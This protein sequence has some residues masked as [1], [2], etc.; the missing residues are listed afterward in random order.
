[1][2]GAGLYG[3]ARARV[4]NSL[5]PITARIPLG[6]IADE[7]VMLGVSW[8]LWKGKVPILNKLDIAKKAGMAGFIVESARIGEF[9]G[10]QG[11]GGMTTTA[12][13]QVF[14]PTVI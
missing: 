13:P 3:A 1:M 7:A 12:K 4:S 2:F 9:I 8:A 6:G 14:G 10:T 5:S 11:F